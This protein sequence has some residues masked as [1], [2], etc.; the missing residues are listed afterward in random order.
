[1][2]VSQHYVTSMTDSIARWAAESAAAAI[3]YLYHYVS[4]PTDPIYATLTPVYNRML[5][6]ALLMTGALIAFAL[7]ERVLGGDRGAGAVVVIRTLAASAAAILGLPLVRYSINLG[8]LLATAWNG[9]VFTGANALVTQIVP[10]ASAE[11]GA[12]LGSS[13][14]L[15]LTALL[16][17]FLALLVHLELVLRAALLSLTTAFLPLTCVLAIWPRLGGAIRHMVGFLL[18]L[19]LSKFVIATAMY[20]GV[21]MVVRSAAGSAD[22]HSPALITGL[23]TL[24]AA[25]LSPVFLL[26]G[27][28]F[29]EAG[30][31]HASRSFAAGS[32]RSARMITQRPGRGLAGSVLAR[33][34]PPRTAAPTTREGIVTPEA[35]R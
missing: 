26:Q 18:A 21:A 17:V 1:M 31:A 4:Q 2:G 20:L 14:G 13:L 24:V 15:I 32:A 5:A 34:R 11:P 9:D 30:A 27:L 12:A 6:I 8:D 35:G 22:D 23:A 25:L 16:T 10:S 7:M 33:I 19:I 3:L 29:A 28:R